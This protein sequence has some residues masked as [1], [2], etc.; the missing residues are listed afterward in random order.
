MRLRLILPQP[1]VREC[2]QGASPF[3]KLAQAMVKEWLGHLEGV[4]DDAT[5]VSRQA[6]QFRRARMPRVDVDKVE[7]S[8]GQLLTDVAKRVDTAE[9]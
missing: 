5:F 9:C 3:A 6:G 7:L 8:A 1:V 4:R 2:Q